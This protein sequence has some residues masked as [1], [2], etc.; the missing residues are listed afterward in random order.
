MGAGAFAW[1]DAPG[2]RNYRAGH[3]TTRTGHKREN[4]AVLRR[5]FSF[6]VDGGQFAEDGLYECGIDGRRVERLDRSGIADTKGLKGIGKP[7]R[8]LRYRC[9]PVKPA[10]IAVIRRW[11]RHY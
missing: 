7:G 4:C 3:R 11:A 1:C 2:K 9:S 6:G 5:R 10:E 8:V